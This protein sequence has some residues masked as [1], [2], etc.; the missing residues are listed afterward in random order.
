MMRT[1][2]MMMTHS[3]RLSS[4]NHFIIFNR[5]LV[6]QNNYINENMNNDKNIVNKK[7]IV[8]IGQACDHV[9]RSRTYA[10]TRSMIT[11]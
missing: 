11:S 5:N 9:A 8:V 7:N 4:H 2:M 6:P 1:M 10:R 3:L